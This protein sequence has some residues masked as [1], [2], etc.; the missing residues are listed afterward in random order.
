[1]IKQLVRVK[2]FC[3]ACNHFFIKN[4]IHKTITPECPKCGINKDVDR[5]DDESEEK[6]E[7]QKKG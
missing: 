5:I 4:V 3:S 2:Y 7:I 6:E 1:M